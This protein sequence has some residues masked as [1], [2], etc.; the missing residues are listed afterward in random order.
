MPLCRDRPARMRT[1][2][3]LA[4]GAPLPS[5]LVLP[6]PLYAYTSGGLAPW[7]VL[8]ENTLL[9]WGNDG[10]ATAATRAIA[11]QHPVSGARWPKTRLAQWSPWP[12][13]TSSRLHSATLREHHIGTVQDARRKFPE[14]YERW[15]KCARSRSRGP[16]ASG[17][18]PP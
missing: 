4:Y 9:P 12:F 10:T 6:I 18:I 1:S 2:I 17:A 16:A 3:N 7:P 8:V 11:V 13:R 15:T 14:D 5:D